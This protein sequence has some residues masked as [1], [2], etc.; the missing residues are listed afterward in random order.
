MRFDQLTFLD[1]LPISGQFWKVGQR[2]KSRSAKNWLHGLSSLRKTHTAYFSN[3]IKW[4]PMLTTF[5]RDFSSPE[6]EV[7]RGTTSKL[8]FWT[9]CPF[10]STFLKSMSKN[11]SMTFGLVKVQTALPGLGPIWV[12]VCCQ[13]F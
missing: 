11:S 8:I 2:L 5:V 13:H 12:V 3:V 4:Q 10:L 7:W 6:G 1:F 9:S